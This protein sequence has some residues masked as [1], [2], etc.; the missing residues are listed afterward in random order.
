MSEKPKA[1]RLQLEKI[2]ELEKLVEEVGVEVDSE[3]LDKKKQ[4]ILSTFYHLNP[5]AKQVSLGDESYIDRCEYIIEEWT[6]RIFTNVIPPKYDL[7]FDQFAQETF[8]SMENVI[9]AYVVKEWWMTKN[10]RRNTSIKYICEG[11]A[12]PGLITAS[13]FANDPKNVT[14]Y[15]GTAGLIVGF[16]GIIQMDNLKSPK[17]DFSSLRRT[18]KRAQEYISEHP[19]AQ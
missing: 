3:T 13:Y 19:Y 6:P 7:L 1:L 5:L 9:G 2:D 14:I 16:E 10:K 8:D 12:I 18:A 17:R 4:E 11:I 15:A